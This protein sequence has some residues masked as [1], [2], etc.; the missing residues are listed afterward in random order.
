MPSMTLSDLVLWTCRKERRQMKRWLMLWK[1]CQLGPPWRI[2]R[3]RSW[4]HQ[5]FARASTLLPV[6]F[7]Q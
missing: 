6:G 7:L 4:M 3:S 5:V 2:L 1:M